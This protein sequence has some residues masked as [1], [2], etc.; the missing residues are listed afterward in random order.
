MGT[1]EESP[2]VVVGVESTDGGRLAVLWA[3]EEADRRGLRLR[4]VHALDWPLGAQH[5]PDMRKPWETWSGIFRRAGQRALEE[6]R[7]LALDVHPG[8]EVT[9]ALVDG[10]PGVVMWEQAANAAMV[11]LG[12]RRLSSIRELMTTGS[13][14]VPV[15]AHATCPVVI[16]REPEHGGD[17]PGTVVVGVDGSRAV[18]LAFE[19]ASL[20]G[21]TL[22]ALQ[23]RPFTASPVVGAVTHAEEVAEGRIR[24]AE[25][26]AGWAQKYPPTYRCDARSS[27]VIPCTPWHRRPNTRKCVVVGTRGLGGFKGM[28]LGAVGHGLVHHSHCPVMVVPPERGRDDDRD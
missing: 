17:H 10:Q 15:I 9:E 28:L 12:S 2:P 8:P 4:L 5:D 25:S 27:S 6:A 3:A 18:A 26:L 13:I 21:A 20:R 16:V 22:V 11:V 14:A 24:L 19:E 7:S 23:V 1:F